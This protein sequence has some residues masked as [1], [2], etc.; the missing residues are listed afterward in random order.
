M[1][2][3]LRTTRIAM[4]LAERLGLAPAE[5]P[6]VYFTSLLVHAGCTAGIADFAAFLATDELS[7][8]KD[9]CL[10]DP[11]NYV[12]LF[13]WLRRNAAKGKPL[14]ARTLRM[15]QLFAGGEGAFQEIDRGCSEVGSRIAARLGM[16]EA[17][18]LALYH[19]C[20][21]WNGKGPHRLRREDIPLP[22][23]VVNVAM[24][25]EVFASERGPL[26]AREAAAVRRGKSFDP[27]VADVAIALCNDATFWNNL[28]DE[29]WATVLALEPEPQRY[30]EDAGL[31]DFAYALADI[32]DLKSAAPVA[33]S[34][35]T[36]ELAERL[37]MRMRLDPSEVALTRR[38]ALVHDVGLI[39][40]PSLLLAGGTRWSEADAERFRMHTYYTERI[41]ARPE[42]ITRIGAV[43]AA[44]HEHLDGSGYH[45]G[46]GAQTLSLPARTVAV[47][48]AYVEAEDA[49]AS[50]P[51][52]VIAELRA[53]GTYDP[54]CLSA[55]AVELGTA[56]A[57]PTPPRASWP[58]GLTEREV[59]VLRLVASGLNLK[60]TA[61]RLVISDH[62]VRHHLESIY[63]KA[64]ISS[65]AG[66][67]LFAFERGLLPV[68][69]ARQAIPGTSSLR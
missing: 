25:T 48:S 53:R 49:A 22:G 59:E 43:A 30:V 65:R 38:A 62:T 13:G 47:C 56:G 4:A 35:R 18:Q 50:D 68:P 64:G 17:T 44:H 7:A 12:D 67:T 55:L 9:F 16:A 37:A 10:C 36:A 39:A 1:G 32:I 15:L 52:S 69:G 61:Q 5:L 8:Q 11:N 29:P 6:A 3:V 41:L 26:A 45:R 57:T 21:T 63:S 42:C 54:E 28:R 33:H 31:D 66:A 40:V 58:A 23:R 51:R 2:H 24:I 60:E 34:R 27:Q 19:I 20:E 14:P 46:L